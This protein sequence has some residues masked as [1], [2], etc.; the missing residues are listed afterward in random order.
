MS[1]I[2]M[3]WSVSLMVMVLPPGVAIVITLF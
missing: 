1:V 3:P 2:V